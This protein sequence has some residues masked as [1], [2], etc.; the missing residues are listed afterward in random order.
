MLL[1]VFV[2]VYHM[3][4]KKARIQ[5]DSHKF[6]T[7]INVTGTRFFKSSVYRAATAATHVHQ[8]KHPEHIPA[9]DPEERRLVNFTLPVGVCQ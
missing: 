1:L 7:V 6:H 4:E 3:F 2:S 9:Y 5:T 8:S